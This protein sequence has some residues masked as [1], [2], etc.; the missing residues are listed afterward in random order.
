M[1]FQPII[2]LF[3][4]ERYK[5]APLDCKDYAKYLRFLIDCNI[6]WNYLKKKKNLF[7]YITLKISK[8]GSSFYFTIIAI[9]IEY[10]AGAFAEE[11]ETGG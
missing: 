1:L 11:G 10:P 4:S 8:T 3:D 9:F 6:S 7:D 5:N 2:S